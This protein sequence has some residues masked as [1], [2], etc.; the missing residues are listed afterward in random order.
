MVFA[1]PPRKIVAKGNNP[2]HL[3]IKIT[4]CNFVSE[5]MLLSAP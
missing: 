3:L 1:T 4:A 5:K 2:N